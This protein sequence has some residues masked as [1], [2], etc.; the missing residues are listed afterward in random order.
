MPP[1]SPG[2]GLTLPIFRR[3]LPHDPQTAM[4]V[5]ASQLRPLTLDF[6]RFP[7]HDRPPALTSSQSRLLWSFVAQPVHLELTSLPKLDRVHGSCLHRPKRTDPCRLVQPHAPG[8]LEP[9]PNT[10]CFFFTL[11]PVE[12]TLVTSNADLTGLAQRLNLLAGFV[13]RL[14]FGSDGSPPP[15]MILS[16]D[17]ILQVV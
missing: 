12:G 15:E 13:F 3:D 14:A 2:Q 9:I 4:L 6:T 10:T 11:L 7:P 17:L 16:V 8:A 5:V 1:T